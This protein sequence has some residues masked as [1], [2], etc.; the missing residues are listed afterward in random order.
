MRKRVDPRIAR[1]T[2]MIMK[3]LRKLGRERGLNAITIK[4]ITEAAQVNR[5]TFYYHYRDKNDL[6]EKTLMEDFEVYLLTPIMACEKIN[7]ET[8]RIIY[9]AFIKY[10]ETISI[11]CQ[12]DFSYLHS[13]FTQKMTD[14]LIEQLQLILREDN[15][16]SDD[17]L[18]FSA[19]IPSS[20]IV[21]LIREWM[22][23]DQLEVEQLIDSTTLFK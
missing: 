20:S 9:F 21:G 7:E 22:A 3:S 4:E 15:P 17:Y 23:N 18:R 1:T 6:I 14:Q 10:I 11:Y 19:V 12:G 5:T 16:S 2:K 8:L 13:E